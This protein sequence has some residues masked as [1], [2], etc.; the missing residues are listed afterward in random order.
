MMREIC[1]FTHAQKVLTKTRPLNY[2]CITLNIYKH[3]MLESTMQLAHKICPVYYVQKECHVR[4]S[5]A[6]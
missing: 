2:D 6:N 1:M 3:V 5:Y 4:I